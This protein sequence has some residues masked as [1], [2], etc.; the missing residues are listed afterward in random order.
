MR[1]C[2]REIRINEHPISL[3][4]LACPNFDYAAAAVTRNGQSQFFMEQMEKTIDSD[5]FKPYAPRLRRLIF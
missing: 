4:A 1:L 2:T 3:L 5:R